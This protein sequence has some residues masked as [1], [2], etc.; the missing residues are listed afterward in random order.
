MEQELEQEVEIEEEI[1]QEV[2]QE[3]G[4]SEA[5][6]KALKMGWVPKEEF[7]GDPNNW[8]P[9]EEFVERGENMI[10]ILRKNLTKAEQ[11]AL[12]AQAKAEAAVKH[13]KLLQEKLHKRDQEAYEKQRRLA[14][15]SGDIEAYDSLKAPEPL[16]EFQ[17]PD[18]TPGQVYF[19]ESWSHENDWYGKDYEKTV[20]ADRYGEFLSKSKP[21][22]IGKPEFLD[23]VAEHIQRKFQNPNR[24]KPSMVD[25]ATPKVSGKAGKL[26]DSLDAEAKAAFNSLVKSGIFTNTPS[27]REEYAKDVLA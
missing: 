6:Q 19:K 1:E 9:A 22:L 17:E 3:A 5:E 16:P 20:E 25:S 13:M 14:V 11:R 18:Q 10:P 7:K 23:E 8:R 26:F 24:S 12:D 4:P 15:E 21:D 2:E 27:D